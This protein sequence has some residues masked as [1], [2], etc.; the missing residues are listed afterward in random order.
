M[1]EQPESGFA[2]RCDAQGSIQNVLLDGLGI[3]GLAR[4]KS[5]RQLVDSGSRVKLLN[6]LVELR[7]AGVA[8]GWEINIPLPEKTLTINLAGVSD[9]ND[10]IL[11]GA[12]NCSDALGLSNRLADMDSR[13]AG[14]MRIL[15]AHQLKTIGL[16]ADKDAALYDEISR[17]NNELMTLQ[18]DLAK[19]NAELERLYTEVQRLAITDPLTHLY[20]RRGLFEVGCREIER[21]RRF[22]HPLSA[23]MF[24]LDSFKEIN[25][26]HGHSAGDRVLAE[27]ADRCQRK[28]RKV[29]IFARYGGDEFSVLLPETSPAEANQIA[30][31]LRRI[32][33]LPIDNGLV[34]LKITISL[35]VTGLKKSTKN[36]EE[37]LQ[38]A[39]VAL[40]KAKVAGRNRVCSDD[41]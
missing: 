34:L 12:L 38:S 41:E 28:L 25:D 33:D 17:L 6:F 13:L 16:Q 24:D 19:K 36:L 30:E 15:F 37:L 3:E 39:D 40:Y 23:I 31:R 29:D 32:A 27:I 2:I 8:A 14:G 21:A 18:R 4:G 22:N 1:N 20:N 11:I 10:L 7:A 26:T 9:S 5:L 35:G